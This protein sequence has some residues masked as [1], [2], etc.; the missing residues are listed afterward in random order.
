MIVTWQDGVIKAIDV[1]A[2][3][4][5]QRTGQA[6]KFT[7]RFEDIDGDAAG[8]KEVSET[9][10]GETAADYGNFH[11]QPSSMPAIRSPA[12][13]SPK[14]AGRSAGGVN[15]NHWSRMRVESA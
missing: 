14:I 10:P 1:R 3:L 9:N 4:E 2:V 11:C 13:P 15:V 6:A 7:R 5:H 8:R 12:W